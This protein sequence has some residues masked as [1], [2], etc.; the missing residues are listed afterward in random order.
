MQVGDTLWLDVNF[1][2]SLA[3]YQTRKR[4]RV[5]PQDFSWTTY[6]AIERLE[7][8]GNLPT[9]VANTFQAVAKRG[10]ISIGGSTTGVITLDYD[11]SHYRGRFGFIPT[12]RG[13]VCMSLVASP[14]G[15]TKNYGNIN[16]PFIQLPSGAQGTRPR[17]V[18]A[19][20]LYRINDG[21]ANN[22]DLYSQHT[23]AFAAQPDIALSPKLYELESRFTVEVK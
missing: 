14:P 2:D 21:K 16:L 3:D 15:G 1:A 10:R 7:G 9:G 23:K 13:V 12:Q 17:A 20:M 6:F 22:H 4:Y 8:I 11:G 5:R 18:L 19:D